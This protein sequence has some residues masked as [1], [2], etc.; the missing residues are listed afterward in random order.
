M[1]FLYRFRTWLTQVSTWCMGYLLACTGINVYKLHVNKKSTDM[2]QNKKLFVGNNNEASKNKSVADINYLYSQL[3][4]G[5]ITLK[6][7][8]VAINN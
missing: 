8:L 2:K 6:E 4:I 7:Y 3:Y 5:N 1:P